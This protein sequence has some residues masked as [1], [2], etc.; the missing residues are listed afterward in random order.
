MK[1]KLSFFCTLFSLLLFLS[2][3]DK[4]CEDCAANEDYT[5]GIFVV[6]EGTSGGGG[7]IS[8]YNPNTGEVRDSIYEKVNGGAH[9]GKYIQSLAF[10]DGKGYI[11]VSGA[12]RIVVVDA[13]TFRFMD[14]IGGFQIPRYFMPVNN[15]TA[16]VSQWGADGISGSLAKVDLDFNKITKTIPAGSGPEKMLYFS[17]TH[18][19]YVANSGGYGVDSTI[20]YLQVDVDDVV[21]K[22]IIAGQR[23]PACMSSNSQ[24]G[25]APW[26]V[27]CKG[28]WMDP[29]SQGWL[30]RPF[31]GSPTGEVAPAF[32]DDL[33]TSG[34]G[35][36]YFTSGTAIYRV[37]S[38]GTVQKAFDQP[39]YGF[40]A[41][42]AGSNLYCADA[43]D[44]NSA[45]E[46][47]VRKGDGTTVGSFRCGISPGEIVIK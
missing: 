17:Q 34:D 28:D 40:T 41:D 11:V 27:L 31:S 10:Y 36:D 16:F 4:R 43:K 33:S 44:F 46:V 1:V 7:T 38:D 21:Q 2:S 22:K 24:G 32:S 18:Q 42:P 8:W 14:T 6:N 25:F 35:F 26:N 47:V 19:L 12:N 15:S 39:A 3:C 29:L 45:G 37:K 30:G 9:L 5:S 20:A 23:N 13:N